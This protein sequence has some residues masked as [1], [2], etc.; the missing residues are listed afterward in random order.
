[1]LDLLE[2]ISATRYIFQRSW[3]VLER[4][5]MLLLITAYSCPRAEY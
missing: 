5:T 4:A 3:Y 1:M 2:L